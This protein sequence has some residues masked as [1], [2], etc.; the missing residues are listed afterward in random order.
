MDLDDLDPDPIAQLATWIGEARSAGIG[1]ADAFALATS[2]A[3]GAPSVRML[4][5][6]GLDHR[7]L[8]FYTNRA[9]RKGRDLVVNPRAAAVFYWQPLERQA[10]LA[11]LV[12]EIGQVESMTYFAT[13]ARGSRISAWASAQG[14][15]VDGRAALDEQW[16]AAESRFPGEQIPL[17]AAWGGYRLVP[18]AIEFW[19]SRADRLHDRIEYRLTTDR[20]WERRR[21]QP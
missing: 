2:G 16:A 4:L 17:P 21:L 20:R 14:Q 6:R 7:G 15:P 11:G 12:Q 9:S 13:R 5:A 1:L 10:R 3:D 18:E 19:T 8:A